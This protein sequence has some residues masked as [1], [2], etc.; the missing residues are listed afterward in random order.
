M[1]RNQVLEEPRVIHRAI[2]R[3]SNKCL[4]E[5]M[6][7]QLCIMYMY[8]AGQYTTKRDQNLEEHHISIYVRK[9]NG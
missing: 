4:N 5:R 8:S 1:R 3:L 7:G 9:R 6:K 2:V